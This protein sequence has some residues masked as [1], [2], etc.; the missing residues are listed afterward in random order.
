MIV[1]LKPMVIIL[2]KTM[3]EGTK[4]KEYLEAWL[5]EWI[6]F[7]ISSDGYSRELVTA[8]SPDFVEIMMEKHNTVLKTVLKEISYGE[9]YAFYNVYGPYHNRKVLWEEFFSFGLLEPKNMI[10]GGDLNLTL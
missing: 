4:Y 6:F 7:H 5:K 3:M 9:F 10:M 1:I 2:Q 8:W